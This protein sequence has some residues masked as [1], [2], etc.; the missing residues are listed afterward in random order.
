[1]LNVNNGNND[2]TNQNIW[3]Q[4]ALFN[5]LNLRT[6]LNGRNEFSTPELRA[7]M[8]AMLDEQ[9]NNTLVFLKF[10]NEVLSGLPD[11][12]GIQAIANERNLL[13][14]LPTNILIGCHDLGTPGLWTAVVAMAEEQKNNVL[15]FPECNT[16]ELLGCQNEVVSKPLQILIFFG[17]PSYKHN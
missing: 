8:A 7:A 14:H 15:V 10:N 3:D 1:M 2:N 9:R 16:E 11:E 12:R 13:D 17:L 5:Q 4:M 6:I